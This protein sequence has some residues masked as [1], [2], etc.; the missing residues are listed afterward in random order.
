MAHFGTWVLLAALI[1]AAWS[2]TASV[3]GARRRDRRLV[4]SGIHAAYGVMA[5]MLLASATIIHAFV[6][7]DYSIKYVQHY[8]DA[9]M[10]IVYKITA[11][12]GGLDGSLMFWV[13]ILSVFSAIAI[14]RNR[15][16]HRELIP[17]VTAVCMGVAVF[18]LAMLVFVKNPFDT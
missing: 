16:R 6:S 10:P 17:Y 4:A 12:W 3:V 5:L 1:V 11:Y 9:T 15:E 8:S 13:L 7:N 14:Y 18:F 2:A